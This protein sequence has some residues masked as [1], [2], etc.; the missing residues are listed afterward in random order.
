MSI[1]LNKL[2]F[3]A[4]I[5]FCITVATSVFGQNL[6]IRGKVVDHEN[7][8]VIGANV[9]FL[10]SFQG[11]AT[12]AEGEFE[13][14]SK[15]KAPFIYVISA[16]GFETVQDTIFSPG[17]VQ[18]DVKLEEAI[19]LGK[20]VV[21]SASLVEE[22]IMRS[23]VSVEKLELTQIQQMPQA[24][25]YDGLAQLKGIDMNTQSLTFKVSIY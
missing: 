17:E 11:Q 4:I 25:F 22:N 1:T 9:Y 2:R 15:G 21:V 8:P 24:N 19:L 10:T 12:N 18:V 20:E 3:F 6:T 16:V 5:T 13:I 23:T 7:T 14:R